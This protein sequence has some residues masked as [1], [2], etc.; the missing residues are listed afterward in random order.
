MATMS[1]MSVDCKARHDS[2]ASSTL[3]MAAAVGVHVLLFLVIR[4]EMQPQMQKGVA[5]PPARDV[6][7][8]V[9]FV[10][11]ASRHEAVQQEPVQSRSAPVAQVGP[12]IRPNT[13]PRAKPKAATV[14]ETSSIPA[15]NAAVVRHSGA[16]DVTTETT[17]MAVMR[18]TE[19]SPATPD[20]A[21][22]QPTDSTGIMSHRS[23]VGYTKSRF[24]DAW[25]PRDESVVSEGL[26]R[27]EDAATLKKTV[28]FGHGVR[29]HCAVGPLGG[30]CGFGDAPS[31]AAAK[32]GDVR[33]SMAPAHS[34]AND[35]PDTP[36]PPSEAAC[37]AAYRVD[38]RVPQGCPTDTPLK[39]MDAENAERVRRTGQP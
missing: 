15:S 1:E 12:A 31:K 19:G 39:A 6:A 10:E 32:D 11:R 38:A 25:V 27:A 4:F 18:N 23:I 33:L 37:V 21:A 5:V 30:G 22:P 3:A 2:R 17:D 26:R 13:A 24:D 16:A 14:P 28:D 20:F 9:R 7:L 29:M 34:L 8:E 35:L 36:T